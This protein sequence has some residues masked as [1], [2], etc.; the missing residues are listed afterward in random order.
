MPRRSILRIIGDTINLLRSSGD[1]TATIT[2]SGKLHTVVTDTTGLTVGDWIIIDGRKGRVKSI[3]PTQFVAH[4]TRSIDLNSILWRSA[5][6]YYD[7]GNENM[8]ENYLQQETDDEAIT[9][10]IILLEPF[11]RK[12]SSLDKTLGIG[13]N[14][15]LVILVLDTFDTDWIKTEQFYVN[16]IE[17]LEDI[18]HIIIQNLNENVYINTPLLEND[19]YTKT[20]YTGKNIFG[21]NL[22][23]VRLE[24]ELNINERYFDECY[25]YVPP[26]LLTDQD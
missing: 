9:P 17:N 22:C 5:T 25:P 8:L 24:L 20:S 7:S 10:L 6:P 4:F 23:G 1:I 19:G 12:V 26:T 21:K 2:V 15:K 3:T 16:K 11:K 13:E 14:A 18:S